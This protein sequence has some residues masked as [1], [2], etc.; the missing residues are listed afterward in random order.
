MR[1]DLPV[2]EGNQKKDMEGRDEERGEEICPDSE[3][4]S[5]Y[6]VKFEDCGLITWDCELQGTSKSI[7]SS[8]A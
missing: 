6:D 3:R 1:E 2:E 7:Q 4:T 8:G 5:Y